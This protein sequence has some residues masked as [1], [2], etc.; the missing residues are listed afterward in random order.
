MMNSLLPLL[1][2]LLGTSYAWV[3]PMH[4][5]K[6]DAYIKPRAAPLHVTTPETTSLLIA[7]TESW[8]QYVPL[9]VSLAVIVDILLG[10]PIA[11]LA[12]GPMRRA[13]E[14]GSEGDDGD[15]MADLL[16][17]L[18]PKKRNTRARVDTN[19][20][21]QEAVDQAKATLDFM[22]YMEQNKSDDQRFAELRQQMDSQKRDVDKKLADR[23]KKIDA[24][25]Y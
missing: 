13:S 14:K 8:R 10:S 19:A 11:N 24:G 1:L 18:Q 20:I 22:E 9:G 7:E 2:F 17:Q 15:G 25:E 4:K 3:Q 23:Q 5:A 12:L 21:A 6:K 16:G